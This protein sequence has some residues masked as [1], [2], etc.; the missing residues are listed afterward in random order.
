MEIA[1]HSIPMGRTGTIQEVVNTV[2]YLASD[3][4]PFITG[5]IVPVCGA[6]SNTSY[7]PA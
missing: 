6:Y 3:K 2:L 7:C 4:A 5:A 1:D